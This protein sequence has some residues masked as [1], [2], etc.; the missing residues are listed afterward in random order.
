M[1]GD[2]RFITLSRI[3][4]YALAVL[5]G[6]AAP[7]WGQTATTIPLATV[8]TLPAPATKAGKIYMVT[9]GQTATS[10][11]VGGGTYQVFCQSTGTAWVQSGGTTV[12]SVSGT[13]GQV[14]VS[15]TTGAPVVSLPS[16][17]TLPGTLTAG[18][19][20]SLGANPLQFTDTTLLNEG[21]NTLGQRNG[22]NAQTSRLYNTYT[23]ATNFERL[24]TLWSSNV[25]IFQTD[26][27]SVGGTA[28]SMQFRVGG[29]D[30]G[31]GST[32]LTL[33]NTTGGVVLVNA[34]PL[35]TA[36]AAGRFDSGGGGTVSAT[37]GTHYNVRI[38]E[39]HNP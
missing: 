3:L 31:L 33:P 24:D 9:D 7:A 38:R 21:S 36:S 39:N 15:P 34:N 8:A 27:G 26:R 32:L 13:A 23:S 12:S 25:A 22:T 20:V 19:S 6:S 5:L 37:S 2:M 16:A 18:G 29:I 17:L 30:G 14:T 4:G 11:T 35:G 10:G 28:R 1:R